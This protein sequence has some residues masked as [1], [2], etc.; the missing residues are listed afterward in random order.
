MGIPAVVLPG[1]TAS[2]A[3]GDPIVV[4]GRN[5]AVIRGDE[6]GEAPPEG[7]AG[8]PDNVHVSPRRV[9]PPPGRRSRQAAKLRLAFFVVWAVFFGVLFLAPGAW[10]H[11]AAIGA[12]DAF[13]WPVFRALG[14]VLTVAVVAAAM[15]AVIMGA[16]RLLVDHRRLREAKR[17]QKLLMREAK[18]LP[19]G[20]PRHKKLLALAAPVQVRLLGA[21]MVALIVMLGPMIVSFIWLMQ[22]VAPPAWNPPAGSSVKIIAMVD[23]EWAGPLRLEAAA[24]LHLD[25]LVRGAGLVQT[26]QPLRPPLEQLRELLLAGGPANKLPPALRGRTGDELKAAAEDLARQ[27]DGPLPPRAVIWQLEAPESAAG[28][29][30]VTVRAEG[31]PPVTVNVVMGSRSPPQPLEVAG[32]RGPLKSL[33]A[34]FP[35]A[36]QKRIFWAPVPGRSDWDIGWPAAYVIF[37]VPVM[38]ALKF[39]LR[40][41]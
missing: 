40:I 28:S 35:R 21:A 24:P 3:D 31:A 19:K 12:F 29:F 11:D 9:P 18:K 22:R 13:L 27:L 2:L 41:P 10:L 5:G 33:K 37:Y 8:E 6:P 16:Q 15:A 26:P 7:E 20:S 23:S 14:P 34:A 1:A 38:F 36:E 30:P 25:P 17:R 4:D 32:D 39:L